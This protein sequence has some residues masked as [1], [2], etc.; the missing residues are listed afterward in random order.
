M[1]IG[2]WDMKHSSQLHMA[3]VCR[4]VIHRNS[5]ESKFIIHVTRKKFLSFSKPFLFILFNMSK[6]MLR[7][8]FAF[9]LSDHTIKLMFMLFLSV[10]SAVSLAK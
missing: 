6:N 9:F 4:M 7:I 5:K 2:E 10:F 3:Y 1:L 8:V